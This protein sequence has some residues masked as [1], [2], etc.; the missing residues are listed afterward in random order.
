MKRACFK[1]SSGILFRVDGLKKIGLGFS[2]LYPMVLPCPPALSLDHSSPQ[3][4]LIQAIP[5]NPSEP[6]YGDDEIHNE[7]GHESEE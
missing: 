6:D 7:E 2:T 1:T 5:R 4:S 3:L